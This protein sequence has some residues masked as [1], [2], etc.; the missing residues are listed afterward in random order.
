MNVVDFQNIHRAY[1]VGQDVLD[2]VTFSVASGEV[3]GLLGKN[4]AGKTTLL[5]VA[6][7]LIE[8]QQG[9]ARVFGGNSARCRNRNGALGENAQPGR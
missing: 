1:Q 9:S 8:S 4:G 5:R 2:G 6:M 3:V 7:G